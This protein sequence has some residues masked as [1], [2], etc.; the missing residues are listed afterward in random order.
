VVEITPASGFWITF[1][2]EWSYYLFWVARGRLRYFTRLLVAINNA[3][4]PWLD[5]VDRRLNPAS[6]NFTWMYL[7]VAR[8]PE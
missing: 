4:F 5:R 3:V 2:S 1:G 8:K 6:E 7:L